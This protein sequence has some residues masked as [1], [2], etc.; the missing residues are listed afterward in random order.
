MKIIDDTT[1]RTIRGGT[2]E[3]NLGL[4]NESDTTIVGD[5]NVD[6]QSYAARQTTRVQQRSLES[7]LKQ[8]SSGFGIQLPFG[9]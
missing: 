8:S 4:T 7:N 3:L 5:G 6:L 9:L 1:L 2:N